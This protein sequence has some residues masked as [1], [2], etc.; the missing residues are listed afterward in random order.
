M[1]DLLRPDHEQ[2]LEEIE[3]LVTKVPTSA[4]DAADAHAAERAA[5]LKVLERVVEL[6][7]PQFARLADIIIVRREEFTSEAQ[8]SLNQFR[9]EDYPERGV[10]IFEDKHEG[11]T[12]TPGRLRI[13]ARRIYLLSGKRLL[14]VESD[15]ARQ[16]KK[17]RR[18]R[19]DRHEIWAPR[20]AEVT[21]AE[22]LDRIGLIEM[23]LDTV[24]EQLDMAVGLAEDTVVSSVKRTA[25]LLML[26]DGMN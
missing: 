2:A 3:R 5:E 9:R 17:R 22:A 10:L 4:A 25:K 14:L 11:G 18:L 26:V 16:E 8:P 21:A 13:S 24:R 20:T 7:A 19:P 15:G 1:V 6:L 12:D 23:V